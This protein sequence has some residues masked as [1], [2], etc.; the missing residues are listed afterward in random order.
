MINKKKKFFQ[1][2]HSRFQNVKEYGHADVSSVSHRVTKEI[3]SEEIWTEPHK[4]KLNKTRAKHVR[5]C[6]DLM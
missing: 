1:K 5:K 4:T 2:A 6:V 3:V